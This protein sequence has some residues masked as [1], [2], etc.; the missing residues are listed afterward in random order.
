MGVWMCADVYLEA[1]ALNPV[2]PWNTQC[3]FC[4][5]ACVRPTM[6]KRCCKWL[7]KLQSCKIKRRV[8]LQAKSESSLNLSWNLKWP[9][10]EIFRFAPPRARTA[11]RTI[12][13]FNDSTVS[14]N[15]FEGTSLR[16]SGEILQS[17]SLMVELYTSRSVRSSQGEPLD[18]RTQD[19]KCSVERK[20]KELRDIYKLV[21]WADLVRAPLFNRKI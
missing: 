19:R 5:R 4:V 7:C 6:C 8:S 20:T 9:S 1:E 15:W 18:L 21:N 17:N 11:A 16:H 13:Q 12:E 14:W 2:L 10:T 3:L